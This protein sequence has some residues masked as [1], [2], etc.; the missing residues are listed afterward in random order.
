M[1]LYVGFSICKKF[2]TLKL[3]IILI[4]CFGLY[5]F[6]SNL[7]E[8]LYL[9]KD[10]IGVKSFDDDDTRGFLWKE[11]FGDLN[12]AEFIFGRGFLGTYFSEYFLMILIHYGTYGDHY[13]RFSVEVGFLQFLLKGGFF[14]YFLFIAPL[15]YTSIKGIFWHYRDQLVFSISIFLFTELMLMYIENIPYFSFQY[16]LIFFLAGFAIRRMKYGAVVS[17]KLDINPNPLNIQQRVK[18]I[19]NKTKTI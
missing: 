7:E 11:V 2:G 9:F 17:D 10:I 13:E 16:S 3:F 18:S 12:G 15:L 4:C 19:F 14:W 5:Q 1:G 8:V 6:I